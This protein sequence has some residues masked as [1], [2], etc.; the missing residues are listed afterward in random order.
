MPDEAEQVLY[1]MRKAYAD[2]RSYRDEGEV[3]TTFFEPRK[4]TNR[5]RFST[6]FLRNE[7]FLFE[8]RSRRGEDDWDQY[9][10]WLDR[11]RV[12][13]WW[14]LGLAD[15]DPASLLSALAAATGVSRGAAHTVP[16]MLTPELAEDAGR[17]PGSTS[18]IDDPAAAALGCVVVARTNRLGIT[19][20]WWI[21]AASFTLRRIV[22][23]RRAM[24]MPSTDSM[25]PEQL[26]LAR[27]VEEQ[28]ARKPVDVESVTTYDAALNVAVGKEELLFSPTNE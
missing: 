12:R 2:C 13:S 4:R 21:D 5:L 24:T 6:R 20:H 3:A 1:R 15:P 14:T 18:L 17:Y 11:G 10:V 19:E 8:F 16:V 27:K 23:P 26:E 25:S 28:L 9:A 7:G 22:A